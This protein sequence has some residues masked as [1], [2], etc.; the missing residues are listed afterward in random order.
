MIQRTIK[1]AGMALIVGVLAGCA[2]TGNGMHPHQV[3]HEWVANDRV[4][5][6][7]FADNNSACQQGAQSV[8]SYE[9][10][11]TRHGYALHNNP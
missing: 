10:C 6:V 9:S 2:A 8:E 7:N 1:A 4:A 5:A 11:M 3:T